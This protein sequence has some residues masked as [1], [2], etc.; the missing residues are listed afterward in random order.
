MR[1]CKALLVLLTA[2]FLLNAELNLAQAQTTQPADTSAVVGGQS[3]AMILGIS[4]YQHIRP[5]SYADSDAG[6]FRDY[7]KSAGAGSIPDDRMLFLVNEQ[8]TSANF[9]VKGMA[10]LRQKNLKS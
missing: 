5:L 2:F 10:W 8:A 3:Y 1:N 7:L 4:T 9:W 6:L